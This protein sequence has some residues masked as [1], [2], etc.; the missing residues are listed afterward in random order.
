MEII[1]EDYAGEPCH[2]LLTKRITQAMAFDPNVDFA[3]WRSA[4]RDRFIELTGLDAIAENACAPAL[5]IESVETYEGYTQTR[6]TFASEEGTRVPCYLLVPDTAQGSYPVAITMQGHSTG[7][8]NSVGIIK[9]PERDTDYQPRGCFGIQAVRRGY[10]ALCIE[11][12]GMGE[13]CPTE[14][15]RR[16]KT[17]QYTAYTALLLGRTILGERIWDISRAIDVLRDHFPVCNTEQVLI[18]GNSGGGT[19]SFY[20]ACY[21]ER[22]KLSVPS[23][24]FCPYEESILDIFHCCCNYIPHAYKYFEMQDLAALIAPRRL[25]VVAG[26]EDHIFPIVGVRRGF[27]TVRAIYAAAGADALCRLELTPRGHWWCED[28]VWSAIDR[29]AMALGWK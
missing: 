12:R 23:C 16:A 13:R 6:F 19:A 15:S 8:H 27:E 18:T 10:A 24:A 22:I 21:D 20:A 28:I 4:L 7:F 3:A 9:Y 14:R 5:E 17:C 1:T 11:Q 25:V 2:T 26:E 29:E